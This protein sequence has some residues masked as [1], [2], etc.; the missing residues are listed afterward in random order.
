MDLLK[1]LP[2]GHG[3]AKPDALNAS[4]INVLPGGRNDKGKF[5]P[6][7]MTKEMLGENA[8]LKPGDTQHFIFRAGESCLADESLDPNKL[9]DKAKGMKQIL[10]ERGLWVDGMRAKAPIVKGVAR[11]DLSAKDVLSKQR[12][13][14][15]ET[16]LLEDM[17]SKRGHFLRPS[18]ICH[19]EIAGQG[20][21]YTW[22][23][24]KRYYRGMPERLE[25]MHLAGR[26]MLWHVCEALAH[27]K[28]AHSRR[29]ARK[30]ESYKKAYA[31]LDGKAEL[32]EIEALK[33]EH[34][35]HRDCGR[36]EGAFISSIASDL[37]LHQAEWSCSCYI[38]RTATKCR[39]NLSKYRHMEDCSLHYRNFNS[40]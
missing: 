33:K 16:T 6:S 25:N 38:C 37:D 32:S 34:S 8:T 3:K 35:T 1:V 12:D 17:V 2:S 30:C 4:N 9:I 22:G 14:L 36:M 21:E 7:V 24:S 15:E 26:H 13:F 40:R 31:D 39:C 10:M 19:P 5:H 29:F 18:P 23:M 20:V 28:P 27:V 11:Y